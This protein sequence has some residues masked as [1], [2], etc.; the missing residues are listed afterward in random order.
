MA[1][2]Y[3]HGNAILGEAG[4]A[5]ENH[6]KVDLF[7]LAGQWHAGAGELRF[8]SG[9]LAECQPEIERH[10]AGDG[11]KRDEDGYYRI[12]GRVDDVM[13]V[14][15]HRIGTAEV[16]S[17]LNMHPDI[18]ES[19]VVGYPHDIKGQG[20]YAYVICTNKNKDVE[21]NHI[22]LV[23]LN[24]YAKSLEKKKEKHHQKNLQ[25]MSTCV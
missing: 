14:S 16:E 12:T 20:I 6:H 1:N 17:A 15:G 3:A 19:A 24:T 21:L 5:D 7:N 2:R 8:V 4:S 9:T 25:F 11:C 22:K 23:I 18:V 10:R 13:N